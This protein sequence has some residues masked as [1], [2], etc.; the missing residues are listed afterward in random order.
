MTNPILEALSAWVEATDAYSECEPGIDPA[1]LTRAADAL[2]GRIDDLARPQR[3]AA[4]PASEWD[5]TLAAIMQTIQAVSDRFTSG[6]YSDDDTD[7]PCDVEWDVHSLVAAV[8]PSYQIPEEI[9]PSHVV[10][11]AFPHPTDDI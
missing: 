8:D 2:V 11:T 4:I 5:Q 9:E 3:P 1:P 6:E 7:A 10:G